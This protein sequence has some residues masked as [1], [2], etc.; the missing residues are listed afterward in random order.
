[1]GPNFR[2][3]AMSFVWP[4][5]VSRHFGL[6]AFACM[7]VFGVGWSI[8]RRD[9]SILSHSTS[10]E[11]STLLFLQWLRGLAFLSMVL[12]RV[13]TARL[14]WSSF[15]AVLFFACAFCACLLNCLGYLVLGF[16]CWSF[17]A[18]CASL[19]SSLLLSS[20]GFL[21]SDYSF[22]RYV[23]SSG[24]VVVRSIAALSIHHKLLLG[25]WFW[26]LPVSW[27]CFSLMLDCMLCCLKFKCLH[28]MLLLSCL[29]TSHGLRRLLLML[30]SVQLLFQLREM[31]SSLCFCSVR[32]L[33]SRCSSAFPTSSLDACI[34]ITYK[35][36]GWHYFLFFVSCLLRCF[37][38]L[39]TWGC[40]RITGQITVTLA[41]GL[42]S[43]L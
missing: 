12:L 30:C 35:N 21:G 39:I 23:S 8:I 16:V 33:P 11:A 17:G 3:S 38:H 1:M 29:S 34:P 36:W 2:S 42:A 24:C 20:G 10:F 25:F 40:Q 6:L 5:T 32:L 19:T 31:L 41:T 28:S 15:I 18:S 7:A 37:Q 22:R 13:F 43:H 4:T 14:P 27:F 9:D 26:Q